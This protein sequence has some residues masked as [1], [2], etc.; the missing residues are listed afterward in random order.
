ME[1]LIYHGHQHLH[2]GHQVRLWGIE[3]LIEEERKGEPAT[4]E[5]EDGKL[6]AWRARSI[7]AGV[8][9]AQRRI[10]FVPFEKVA[11]VCPRCHIGEDGHKKEKGPEKQIVD[12]HP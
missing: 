4:E 12:G 2:P 11:L 9:Q 5:T 6:S 8:R 10:P 1:S 3:D 7:Q